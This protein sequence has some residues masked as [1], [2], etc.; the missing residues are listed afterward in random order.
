VKSQSPEI[1]I[2]MDVSREDRESNEDLFVESW[3][4]LN[5][6]IGCEIKI[7]CLNMAATGG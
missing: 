7:R 3:Q 5:K 2:L 6:E 4:K 1:R